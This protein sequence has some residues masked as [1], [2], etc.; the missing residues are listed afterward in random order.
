MSRSRLRN[1]F[2]RKRSELVEEIN[3]ASEGKVVRN[4]H[5]RD[6]MPKNHPSRY[7][8]ERIGFSK[9]SWLQEST[10]FGGHSIPTGGHRKVSGIVRAKVKEEVR[11]QIEKETGEVTS[12]ESFQY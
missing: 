12:P 7:I 10:S 4:K 9:V 6:E 1:K 11:E 2:M 3:S 5:R 8:L